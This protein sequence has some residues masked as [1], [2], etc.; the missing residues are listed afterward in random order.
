MLTRCQIKQHVKHYSIKKR[1]QSVHQQSKKKT[2]NEVEAW[3]QGGSRDILVVLLGASSLNRYSRCS[4][5][6]TKP[7]TTTLHFL[8]KNTGI[9]SSGGRNK[10]KISRCA[11]Q[12]TRT[13]PQGKRQGLKGKGQ[14]MELTI[15]SS[16]SYGHSEF[17]RYSSN[18]RPAGPST[19]HTW[20][21]DQLGVS[22]RGRATLP[23]PTRPSA[24]E[25]K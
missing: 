3:T 8:G 9:K 20:W 6:T 22:I 25:N 4:L 7:P 2:Q 15:Q 16:S 17:V 11:A 14:Q 13:I 12:P 24:P 21:P 19:W 1:Q 18:Q 23:F 5:Q 10:F